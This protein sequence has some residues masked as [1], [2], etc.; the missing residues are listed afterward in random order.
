MTPDEKVECAERI[1]K[2]TRELLCCL[3]KQELEAFVEWIGS[4]SNLARHLAGHP[5]LGTEALSELSR[6][7]DLR[8][9]S[10]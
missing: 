3:D 10:I 9:E 1:R 2:D 4:A 6:N 8:G 7:A 5:D